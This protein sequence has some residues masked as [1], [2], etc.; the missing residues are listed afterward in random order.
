METT[1]NDVTARDIIATIEDD[2]CFKGEVLEF[3]Q[4]FLDYCNKRTTFGVS[5]MHSPLD[6][7]MPISFGSVLTL[8]VSDIAIECDYSDEFRYEI[9]ETEGYRVALTPYVYDSEFNEVL[10]SVWYLLE[11]NV[12]DPADLKAL[13]ERVGVTFQPSYFE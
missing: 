6:S 8:Q 3:L 2:V 7:D 1:N 9:V 11:Y 10:P 5:S 13:C 4:W 12:A